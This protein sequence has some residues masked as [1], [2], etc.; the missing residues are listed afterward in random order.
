MKYIMQKWKIEK[1]LSEDKYAQFIALLNEIIDSRFILSNSG[2]RITFNEPQTR[3]GKCEQVVINTT[4]KVF[5]LSLD[6]KG[7]TPFKCFNSSREKYTKKN[8]GILLCKKDKKLIILLIELK[9]DNLGQYLKQLKAGKNFVKYLI[10]QINLFS[11]LNI[12]NEDI[13][14][15]GIVFH[16]KRVPFKGTTRKQKLIFEDRN[17]LSCGELNCNATYPLAK[18]KAAI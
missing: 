16:T 6:I 1:M 9:S 8:D 7:L 12:L 10:N 17:G 4:Q 15:K 18:I 13:I 2:G 14:Y 11:E 5:T 3:E